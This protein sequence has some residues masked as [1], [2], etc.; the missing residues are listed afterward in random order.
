MG[1]EVYQELVDFTQVEVKNE[2]IDMYSP[3]KDLGETYIAWL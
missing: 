2:H 3:L 1:L